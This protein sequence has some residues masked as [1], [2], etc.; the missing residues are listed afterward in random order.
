MPIRVGP[1][2]RSYDKLFEWM[3]EFYLD[4]LR[5][6]TEN[7]KLQRDLELGLR[8]R[9][10]MTDEAGARYTVAIDSAGPTLTITPL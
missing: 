7:R 6:D 4:A 1:P 3:Q 10:I 9:L 5:V 8:E 2:P